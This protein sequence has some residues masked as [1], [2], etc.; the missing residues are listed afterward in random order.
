Y[1][2]ILYK[3]RLSDNSTYQGRG[4]RNVVLTFE[5]A[6]MTAD[7]VQLK[8]LYSNSPATID[9]TTIAGYDIIDE[10]RELNNSLKHNHDYVS[11]QLHNKNI[12]WVTDDLIT[13]EKIQ[14]RI[15][16]FDHG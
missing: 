7:I 15:S 2:L 16:D 4:R 1:L 5:E 3:P 11:E 12:I 13:V 6:I 14:N 9:I 10:L 8:S